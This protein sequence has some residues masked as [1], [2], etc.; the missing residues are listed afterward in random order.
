MNFMLLTAA[1]G[2]E[3]GQGGLLSSLTGFAFPILLIAVMYFLL[4]RPQRK[5][6]KEVQAMRSNIQVGD[7]IVTAGGIVGRVV[8][9]EEQTNTLVIE[10]SS[11]RSKLRITR[12][13]VQANNTA[14]ETPAETK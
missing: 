12:W 13:A 3:A 14:N 10:S 1:A 5:R 4:L 6:E 11:D 2:T 7:E 9:M 8:K